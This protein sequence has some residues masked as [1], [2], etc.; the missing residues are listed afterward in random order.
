MNKI[1][2]KHTNVRQSLYEKNDGDYVY[3][4]EF[5]QAHAAITEDI[6]IKFKNYCERLAP[7]E[8]CTVHPPS[9]SGAGN[10]LYNKSDEQLFN[11][12]KKT[13]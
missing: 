9:G 4:A 7:S 3:D 6:S 8:K 11:D 1:E 2:E 12:F 10:G 13:I 5:G